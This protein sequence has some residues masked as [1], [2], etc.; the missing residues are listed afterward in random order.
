MKKRNH[1]IAWLLSLAL[2]MLWSCNDEYEIPSEEPNHSFIQTS[3]GTGENY[4]QIYES[5]D[6]IDLSRGIKT[7]E[8]TFPEGIVLDSDSNLMTKSGESVVKVRFTKPGE[9]KVPIVQSFNGAVY[10]QG[11]QLEES[12]FQTE[13]T[14]TIVD[15]VGCDFVGTDIMANNVF[16][17]KN[18]ALNEVMAGRPVSFEF[19]GVG[20][21]TG[22][23]YEFIRE[24]GFI[25]SYAGDTIQHR[26]GSVGKYALQLT[27]SSE[28]SRDTLL[29]TD[30]VNVVQNTVDP[31]V[32]L[33]AI[34]TQESRNRIE[35]VFHR[36]LKDVT[37]CPT[38]AFNLNINNN[39][40]TVSVGVASIT[41]DPAEQYKVY[42]NLDQELYSSDIIVIEYDET[43]GNLESA[44]DVKVESFDYVDMQFIRPNI[45][46]GSKFDYSF[47][48]TTD[49]D[50]NY[51][52]W[53]APWDKFT[54]AISTGKAYSGTQSGYIEM[55][56]L[57][58]MILGQ[59]VGD[60]WGTFDLSS[61][62]NY[63]VSCWVYV[64]DL[65]SINDPAGVDLRY[66]WQAGT[67]WSVP[68][69]PVFTTEFPVGKWVYSSFVVKS[70]GA[71]PNSFQIR[72]NNQGNAGTIKVYLDE[73]GIS[74][75]EDR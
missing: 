18:G 20:K 39:G 71:G 16:E 62:V 50:W 38:N 37:T 55:E 25:T 14:I 70:P 75:T 43:I 33:S 63:R 53:G 45:L 13:I 11:E 3:F 41:Q 27:A 54:F 49:A 2:V 51:L 67:D 7:R 66:Y 10:A 24:D 40:N 6:L 57:G 21:P 65:G 52:W 4:T 34:N 8:W 23:K 32:V 46:E 9:Y 47:E 42:L 56:P 17:N 60:V 36:D 48:N 31:I 74:E 15:S 30:Y 61:G 19:N 1:K 64:E 29:Y 12:D 58:G 5:F 35:M 22:F 69:C 26:F 72:G 28:W 68:G 59:K 73:I 44:D